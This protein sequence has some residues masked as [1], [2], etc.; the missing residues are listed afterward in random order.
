MKRRILM[1]ALLLALAAAL[2]YAAYAGQRAPS[3]F[4]IEPTAERD[5]VHASLTYDAGSRTLRGRQTMTLTNRTEAALTEVVL[6]LYMNGEREN[7]VVVAGV[8]ADG[9]NVTARK[10]EDDPTVLRI[11][12]DWL[13]G[14]TVELAFM[15]MI[16]HE[17]AEDAAVVSLPALAMLEDCAWRTDAYDPL[18]GSSY[19]QAFD[20]VIELTARED[21]AVAFG[22]ALVSRE[23]REDGMAYTA[24]LRGARDAGFAV[25]TG[26]KLHSAQ[27][28]GVLIAAL[29]ATGDQA[30][31]ACKSA[32]Q[33]LEDLEK[34]GFS[35]PF[36]S[37]SVAVSEKL[38]GDALSGLVVVDP[39]WQG[40]ALR[41]QQ[42]TLVGVLGIAIFAVP[43]G[44]IGSGL[45]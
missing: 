10:D 34:L 11:A 4:A 44:L 15:V 20:Y 14:Q 29:G 37:L 6:R 5:F 35:Y 16:T 42:G 33:A 24:Q 26:G 2:G 30:R 43:A 18:A 40:E 8:T 12:L 23:K 27:K 36:A 28:G 19:A 22:G 31:R 45:M 7:S 21:V 25:K 38:G 1:I 13:P 41:R 17:K 9:K 39:Q 3:L 32:E